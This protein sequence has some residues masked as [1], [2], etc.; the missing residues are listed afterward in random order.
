MNSLAQ[1]RLQQAWRLYTAGW[2]HCL[3]SGRG[4]S[5]E[6]YLKTI[7][8]LW[9]L[10][11]RHR[12]Q[13]DRPVLVDRRMSL[14]QACWYL[15][16]GCKYHT[17]AFIDLEKDDRVQVNWIWCHDGDRNRGTTPETCQNNCLVREWCRDCDR[18]HGTR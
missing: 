5:F 14:F 12:N 7:P 8:F 10:P 2:Y 4:I 15:G 13:F 6:Q 1:I 9:Q 16:I 17:D 3:P 11:R 18:R